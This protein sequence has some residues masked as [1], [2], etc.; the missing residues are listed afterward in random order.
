[1]KINKAL[2]ALTALIAG[3]LALVTGT[4]PAAA[5]VF[6]SCG[7]SNT[8]MVVETP[9]P[10]RMFG[11]PIQMRGQVFDHSD[12]CIF[13]PVGCNNPTGSVEFHDGV[14]GPLLG[15]GSLH[16]HNDDGLLYI[17]ESETSQ[18]AA[19]GLSGGSHTLQAKYIPGGSDNFDESSGTQNITVL[20]APTTTS[21]VLSPNHIVAGQ[22]VHL[23]GTVAT[24]D[25]GLE[26]GTPTPS[27]MIEFFD[28]NVSIASANV[29]SAGV[30][31]LDWTLFAGGGHSIRAHY[32]TD[33]N[34]DESTSSA[35]GLLVDQ[36]ST[37]S[38]LSQTAASTVFGQAFTATATVSTVAPAA[39]T[40]TG[41][42][43]FLDGAN[44][45]SSAVGL[46]GAGLASFTTS[47]LPPGSHS[48]SAAYA[49]DGNFKP[50]TSNTLPH[51]VDKA[52]TTATLTSPTPDPTAVGQPVTFSAIVT[53]VAP[54]AGTPTG[55][56]QFLDGATPLGA[57]VVLNANAASLTTSAL[58]GGT[59][60]IT[61]AYSGDT[62]FKQSASQ[63][64][65]RTV[66]CNTNITGPVNGNVAVPTTGTTCI[67][68]ATISG[69]VT[70]GNGSR[71]SILNSTVGGGLSGGGAA[72]ILACGTTFAS[73]SL[74]NETG[75]VV[76]G[77]PFTAGCAGNTVTGTAG[78]SQN[79]GGVRIN[80][81]KIGNA[82]QVLGTN[83]G[84]TVIGGNNV[85]GAL[86]CLSNSPAAVNEGHSNTAGSRAGE[87][88]SPT[89]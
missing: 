43:T 78:F 39:G 19:H 30:A 26:A 62:N 3:A 61:A 6:G 8:G 67:V 20:P 89:F 31:T 54:G 45:L 85:T 21:L 76:F 64:V 80:G 11:H 7:D 42:V 17:D 15:S 34:Y 23:T 38:T 24:T 73:V 58:G 74:A 59:H 56:V 88:A 82:L 68:N 44:P 40:P 16:D 37:T 69:G 70:V 2:V 33:F 81:N 83:G 63:A 13:N 4:A 71:L 1:M 48:L 47:T 84:A 53:V 27:G 60:V 49:G 87:C 12:T 22:N 75:Q 72:S 18:V 9:A 14:D 5:C 35:A 51:T 66:T 41:Q 46:N 25:T 36:G 55:A 29:N 86:Q 10:Q 32:I 77:D 52:S 79:H 50:S 65:S 57:P 28:N